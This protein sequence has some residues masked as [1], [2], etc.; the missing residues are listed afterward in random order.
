MNAIARF[1]AQWTAVNTALHTY[2]RDLRPSE[3]TFR[4]AAGQNLLGFTPWR[5]P[6][7]Q[8]WM[9]HTWVRDAPRSGS[10]KTGRGGGR[11][12]SAWPKRTPW[13]AP[14]RSPHPGQTPTRCSPRALRGSARWPMATW[15]RCPT[16]GPTSR[17]IPRITGRS[18]WRKG[19]TC[20]VGRSPRSSSATWGTLAPLWVRR[21]SSGGWPAGARIGDGGVVGLAGGGRVGPPSAQLTRA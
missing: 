13:P 16:T 6:A 9:V 10:G 14:S 19:R 15:S 21:G 20:G 7:S 2:A 1:A 12:G 8:D 11:S 3:W 18:I 17:G 5:I 4:P